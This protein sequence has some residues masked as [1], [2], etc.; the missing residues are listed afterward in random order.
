MYGSVWHVLMCCNAEYSV[1]APYTFFV[2]LEFYD[3][4]IKGIT[5][6]TQLHQLLL[7]LPETVAQICLALL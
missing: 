1:C 7:L 6:P 2:V 3:V 5:A 4:M